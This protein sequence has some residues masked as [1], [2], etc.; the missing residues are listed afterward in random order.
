MCWIWIRSPFR[1]LRCLRPFRESW[2]LVSTERS[3]ISSVLLFVPSSFIV[4][5]LGFSDS[6]SAMMTPDAAE[7]TDRLDLSMSSIDMT[8]TALAM[9]EEKE[10]D[11]SGVG[12]FGRKRFF[13]L[14]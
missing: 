10:C 1:K 2:I 7:L 14:R 11:I 12:K 9:Q 4:H 13:I 6:E 3:N 5:I 8:N